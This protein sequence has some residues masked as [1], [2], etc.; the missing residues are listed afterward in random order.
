M[1]KICDSSKLPFTYDVIS[2]PNPNPGC[3]IEEF[4]PGRM[5]VMEFT[6]YS[7]NFRNVK[8]PTGTMDYNFKLQ[9]TYLIDAGLE[10]V[11][12]PSK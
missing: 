5:V 1:E 7:R 12:T 8:N 11:S 10:T 3:D 2:D 4:R 6:T 9:S